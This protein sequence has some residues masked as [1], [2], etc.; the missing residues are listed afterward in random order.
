MKEAGSPVAL[1]FGSYDR[2]VTSSLETPG[3][4]ALP[5]YGI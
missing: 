3:K 5:H 1:C 2:D 4:R